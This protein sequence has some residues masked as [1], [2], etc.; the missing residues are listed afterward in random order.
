MTS[1]AKSLAGRKR[2]ST[3]WDYFQ[4]DERTDKS[5]CLANDERTKKQCTVTLSGKYSS[6]LIAH[7]RQPYHKE[8]FIAY[9]EKET[10]KKEACL[11]LKRK[12]PCSSTNDVQSSKVFKAQTLSDCLLRQINFWPA[13]SA[14]YR[15]RLDS[16]L[17]VVISTGYP[18]TMVDQPSFRSMIH[19]LEQKFK[20]PGQLILIFVTKYSQSRLN[21]IWGSGH[22]QWWGPLS[23]CLKLKRWAL[24]S[25]YFLL[26]L[27]LS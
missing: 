7:L 8:A 2:E 13:D 14:E 1:L 10:K 21:K 9:E 27:H 25:H 18:V 22:T 6:N 17:D 15:R 24:G 23:R 26:Q 16:V 4:Y 3:V 12:L 20:L 11:G 5:R 19:T